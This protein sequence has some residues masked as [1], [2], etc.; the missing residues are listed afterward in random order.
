MMQMRTLALTIVLALLAVT[1]AGSTPNSEQGAKP[2]TPTY[3]LAYHPP[4]WPD[5]PDPKVMLLR[6][7]L[8]TLFV[9]GLCLA[10]VWVGKRW[11]RGARGGG[12]SGGGQLRV[13]E[14][15]GLGG[16]CSLFLV[17]AGGRQ[18]LAGVDRSGLKALLA[19]PEPFEAALEELQP[20]NERA[21]IVSGTA[22]ERA[23]V[24][25]GD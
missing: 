7:G 6:W 21:R 17:R 24:R 22:A 13:V 10:T 14:V 19:L 5:A 4:S 20:P 11:L 1:P 3:D 16:R 25:A 18:V 15:L 9:L 12:L 8:A 23:S 2:A